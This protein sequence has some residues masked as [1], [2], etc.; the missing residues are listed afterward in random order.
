M[1][2][3]PIRDDLLGMHFFSGEQIPSWSRHRV[4][5]TKDFEFIHQVDSFIRWIDYMLV[6]DLL[7]LAIDPCTHDGN[8][9]PKVGIMLFSSFLL[10]LAVAE[11]I[12]KRYIGGHACFGWNGRLSAQ[13]CGTWM[14]SSSMIFTALNVV[15]AW[16]SCWCWSL[17]D[18]MGDGRFLTPVPR[19]RPFR[20]PLPI[21]TV[22]A[23]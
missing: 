15:L 5:A 16:L 1:I 18:G 23:R 7:Y 11:W 22:L 3:C 2:S 20:S 21:A 9:P 12:S 6:W 14:K 19:S 8:R 4:L 13:D 17:N 10:L